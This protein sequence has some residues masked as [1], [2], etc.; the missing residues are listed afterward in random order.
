VLFAGTDQSGLE[1]QVL[2]DFR[3]RLSAMGPYQSRTGR[4]SRQPPA[5][6]K[7]EILTNA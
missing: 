4:Q 5:D 7:E 2:S 3:R 6:A 1:Q